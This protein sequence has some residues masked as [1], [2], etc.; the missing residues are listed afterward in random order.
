MP[1]SSTAANLFAVFT[2][3]LEQIGVRYMV[4]GSVAGMLY[5][6]PRLTHA[7]QIAQM[8]LASGQSRRPVAEEKESPTGQ[9]ASRV[10]RW[11]HSPRG[12]R[13][14]SPTRPPT[15]MLSTIPEGTTIRPFFSLRPS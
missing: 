14:A 12:T 1:S 7:S 15:F 11:P 9:H 5:G 3:R 10:S 8:R 4:T 6:E 13:A 2:D